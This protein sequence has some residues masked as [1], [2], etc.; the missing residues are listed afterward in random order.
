MTKTQSIRVS[1]AALALASAIVVPSVQAAPAITRF[2]PPSGLFSFN[3]PNPPYIARFLPGQRFDIQVTIRPD[4]GQTIKGV[5]F[6]IDGKAIRGS[7]TLAPAT[8]PGL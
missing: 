4:A 5:K 1:A 2:S 7:V 6:K 8:A 3:D